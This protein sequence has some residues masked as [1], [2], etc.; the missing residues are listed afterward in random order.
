VKR[1]LTGQLKLFL[2]TRPFRSGYARSSGHPAI[3]FAGAGRGLKYSPEL[4]FLLGAVEV[5]RSVDGIEVSV[6]YARN[7]ARESGE[8]ALLSV[9]PQCG[10]SSVS[11]D[12]M[13]FS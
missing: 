2:R 10:L 6:E 12:V 11:R 4:E 8:L 7:D 13:L 9:E 1:H 3:G 5:R